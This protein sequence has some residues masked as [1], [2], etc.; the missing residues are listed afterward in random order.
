MVWFRMLRDRRRVHVFAA[1][2]V[3]VLL[4]LGTTG[5]SAAGPGPVPKSMAALGDSLTR[6]FNACGFFFDC[7]SRSWSTGTYQPVLSHYLRLLALS[8]AI[9]GHNYNDARSGAR[10][11]DLNRQA[12]AAVSQKVDYVTILMGANDACTSSVTSMTSPDTFKSQFQQA[13]TT[14]RRGLPSAYV[15]V[16]S[17]PDVY[18]LWEIGYAS[19]AAVIAWDVY[20]ICQSLLA[21]PRSTAQVDQ[22]RRLK[23]KNQ[24]IGFNSAL[25]AVCAE[26][27]R[28]KFDNNAV[29]NYRFTLDLVSKWDYFHPNA[30]GQAV[31]ADVSYRAGFGW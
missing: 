15:F 10:M 31:L 4:A 25:Q 18:H 24:I 5:V 13:M 22:D 3:A 30:A 27:A 20:N 8:P 29:F 7:T 23:V 17:I 2:M 14:L 16:V 21:N 1:C 12:E 26:Y 9:S 6:G 19:D 28:C 11:V